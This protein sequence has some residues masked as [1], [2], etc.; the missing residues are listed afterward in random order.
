VFG[1]GSEHAELSQDTELHLR[2]ARPR[3]L[4]HV[5]KCVADLRNFLSLA[6]GRPV[7][8]L[9]VTGYRDDFADDRTKL[10]FPIEIL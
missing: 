9:S 4:E 5:F 6:I 10:P 2:F 8:V 1:Q 7:A 3:N